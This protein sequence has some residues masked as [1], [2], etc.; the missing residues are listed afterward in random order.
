M[1]VNKNQIVNG[2][3]KY[4]KSDVLTHIPDKNFRTVATAAVLVITN[5]PGTLN[6]LF[7]NAFVKMLETPNG[8]NVDT[9]SDALKQAMAE[10]GGITITIPAIKF[11]MPEEKELTFNSADVDSIMK[12]IKGE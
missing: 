9:L 4:I 2:I 8:Y 11:L 12:Y 1:E 6:P 7:E 10:T 3:I 5:K